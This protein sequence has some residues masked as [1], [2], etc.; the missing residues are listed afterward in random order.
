MDWIPVIIDHEQGRIITTLPDD[1]RETLV[2]DGTDVWIDTWCA[3]ISDNDGE[4]LYY[5]DNGDIESIT[6]WMPLPEPY[7]GDKA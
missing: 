1:G 3:D 5:L 2:T 7:K 4:L 6:A